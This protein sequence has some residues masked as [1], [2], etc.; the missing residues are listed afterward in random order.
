MHACNFRVKDIAQFC[1]KREQK[2]KESFADCMT[3]T[4]GEGV[5]R[6]NEPSKDKFAS[7]YFIYLLTQTMLRSARGVFC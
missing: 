3:T 6:R 1:D 2:T 7:K 4:S 5:R